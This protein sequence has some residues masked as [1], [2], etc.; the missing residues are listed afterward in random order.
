[1]TNAVDRLEAAGL[2]ERQ[3]HETDR[4]A[5]VLAL[6]DE[7]RRVADAATEALKK[8]QPGTPAFR[9]ALPT[10]GLK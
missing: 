2:V 6:T 10:L 5:L 4:R 3:P 9:A 1:M 8:A 7:G